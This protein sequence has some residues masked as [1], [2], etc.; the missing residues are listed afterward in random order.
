M[1]A[2]FIPSIEESQIQASSWQFNGSARAKIFLFDVFSS[3]LGFRPL[4]FPGIILHVFFPPKKS[5]DVYIDH[6][7]DSNDRKTSGIFA[8]FTLPIGSMYGIFTYIWLIFMVGTCRMCR[9]KSIHAS[10]GHCGIRRKYLICGYPCRKPKQ[11]NRRQNT[12]QTGP[13]S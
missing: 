5:T 13:N 6:Y 9:K 10:Y 3:S 7:R 2:K 8:C 12:Q 11:K 4:Q 1:F